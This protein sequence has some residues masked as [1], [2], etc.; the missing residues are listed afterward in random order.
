MAS[1]LAN[2]APSINAGNERRNQ[3][4]GMFARIIRSLIE[5]RQRQANDQIARILARHG[6]FAINRP[7]S[8][9]Q[10]ASGRRQ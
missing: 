9:V 4:S 6:E 10:G 8:N 5:A 2:Q 7:D 1:A 3:R